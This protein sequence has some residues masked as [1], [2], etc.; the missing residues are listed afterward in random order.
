MPDS[1]GQDPQALSIFMVGCDFCAKA[2]PLQATADERK[3]RGKEMTSDLETT[4]FPFICS[5]TGFISAQL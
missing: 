1:S 4:P 2:W 3:G 5:K